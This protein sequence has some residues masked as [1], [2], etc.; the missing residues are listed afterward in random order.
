M[1]VV[2][3]ADATAAQIEH[4]ANHITS[5]GLKPQVIHGTHQTVIAALGEE[6]P[7]PDRG[8]RAGRGGREGPADHG[9][10]QAGL[11]GAEARADRR[12]GARPGGRR[13]AGRRDRRP[14]LGRERGADRRAWPGSSRRSAPPAC[15]AA[16]SSRGPAPTASRGTRSWASRCWPPRGPRPAW[17][18]SPR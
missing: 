11:V 12:Q 3:K 9:P 10:V 16:R 5:L 15:G 6:R 13:H 4:M 2:M 17:R 18:S 7:G 8:A 1:I 14:L